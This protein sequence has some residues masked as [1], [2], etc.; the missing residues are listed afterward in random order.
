MLSIPVA[1]TEQMG[2]RRRRLTP[3]GWSDVVG[4]LAWAA[5]RGRLRGVPTNY[6]GVLTREIG[7]ACVRLRVPAGRTVRRLGGIT[8]SVGLLFVTVSCGSDTQ[9]RQLDIVLRT[10]IGSG[11]ETA[12]PAPFPH[13]R[14][15]FFAFEDPMLCLAGV[16]LLDTA[17]KVVGGETFDRRADLPVVNVPVPLVQQDLP[18]GDYGLRI[19]THAP[20]CTWMVQEVLNSMSNS[21]TPP[22]PEP[23]PA[24]PDT[25]ALVQN[26][27]TPINIPR[28]GLYRATWMVTAPPS[29]ACPYTISLRT[30]M[31]DTE[32]I[33][34][35]P[36]RG[37]P[38]LSAGPPASGGSSGGRSC[39]SSRPARGQSTR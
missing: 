28:A 16:Q 26:S 30:S 9:G 21:G 20:R 17:G 1:R 27:M 31:G 15:T 35:R 5:I 25:W 24:S 18:E 34:Q 4:C 10:Q 33:G 14:Y 3:Y 23:A 19:T 38:T 29:T 32:L 2:R 39:C 37:A 36:E 7:K 6:N 12:A 11:N 8:L 13:A 22:T